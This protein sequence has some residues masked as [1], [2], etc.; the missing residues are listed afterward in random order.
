MNSLSL[1]LIFFLSDISA[2]PTANKSKANENLINSS[3]LSTSNCN[4]LYHTD[5]NY[6]PHT[7][8][9]KGT[10]SSLSSCTHK[11][12]K[13]CIYTRCKTH[14]HTSRPSFISIS[15]SSLQGEEVFVWRRGG[16]M[17]SQYKQGK[18]G[19][20]SPALRSHSI[21]SLFP[22]SPSFTS[23][24]L[25]PN[26]PMHPSYSTNSYCSIYLSIHPPPLVV[27]LTRPHVPPLCSL[28]L[29]PPSLPQGIGR[30]ILKEEMKARSGCHDN[31][32]WGSRRSSRCSSKEALNNL[33]FSSLNGCK[34]EVVCVC[35]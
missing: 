13:I 15:V 24:S 7:G 10:A 34:F 8:S 20:H 22:T 25:C 29:L 6:Y 31:D 35:V 14:T 9:P 21:K 1:S 5:S 26:Q 23:Y 16:W 17:E 2:S 28:F 18:K 4:S 32:Q 27:P 30:M 33:G 19:R 12:L 3:R 11:S